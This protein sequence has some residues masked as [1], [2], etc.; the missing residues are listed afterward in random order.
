MV[1]QL[2]DYDFSNNNSIGFKLSGKTMNSSGE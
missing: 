2:N 1:F